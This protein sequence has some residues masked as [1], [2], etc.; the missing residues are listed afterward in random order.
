MTTTTDL[1]DLDLDF[2]R[3]LP[4]LSPFTSFRLHRLDGVDGLYA[5]RS[6]GGEV[7]LFVVDPAVTATAYAPD[8]T[9]AMRAEVGADHDGYRI[10][11]V[12]NPADDGVSVNLRAPILVNDATGAASQIIFDDARY[13]IRALLQPTAASVAGPA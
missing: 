6:L 12:A 5:M 11:L 10:F 2:S 13:P 4:G 9:G 3:P 8:I 1:T 7:R